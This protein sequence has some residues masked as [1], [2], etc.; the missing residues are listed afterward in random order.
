[1]PV[2]ELPGRVQRRW[3]GP[4]PRPLRLRSW[5]HCGKRWLGQIG[6]V[7]IGVFTLWIAVLS[8]L[9][10]A[11]EYWGHEASAH[12]SDVR[13]S[14]G[15]KTTYYCYLLYQDRSGLDHQAFASINFPTYH[16]LKP[17]AAVGVRYLAAFPRY[18]S[19]EGNE[20]FQ[21]QGAVM[22]GPF[23][24]LVAL[25]CFMLGPATIRREYRLMS[26]G[27]PAVGRVQATER[28]RS[29][30]T[31]AYEWQGRHLSGDFRGKELGLAMDPGD[32][33]LLLVDPGRPKTAMLVAERSFFQLADDTA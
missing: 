28:R 3:N 16:E 19:L 5:D 18:P 4:V 1:V 17:G 33:V 11:A 24:L 7:L 14:A 25:V 13:R 21:L 30:Q 10:L 26:W 32:D 12:V 6:A 29:V 15:R 23:F 22:S 27:Q 9:P 8:A 31:V 2:S 20:L